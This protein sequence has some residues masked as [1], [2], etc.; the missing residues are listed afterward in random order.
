MGERDKAVIDL[1]L[2]HI[3]Q[4]IFQDTLQYFDECSKA[5]L[6][7]LEQNGELK[8]F[9]EAVLGIFPQAGSYLAPDYEALISQEGQLLSLIHI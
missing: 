2:I 4:A 3:Y 6:E 9:P 8:L 1:S 7:L 5:D